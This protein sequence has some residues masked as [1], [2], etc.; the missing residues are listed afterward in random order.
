[1]ENGFKSRI[2]SISTGYIRT[3]KEAP[4]LEK[5]SRAWWCRPI[6]LG[7]REAEA[8]ELQVQGH[9]ELQCDQGQPM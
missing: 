5:G 1:V 9:P 2:K 7:T 3:R 6:T 4:H 8:R